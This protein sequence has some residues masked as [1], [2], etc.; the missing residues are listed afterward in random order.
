MLTWGVRMNPGN[1][2]RLTRDLAPPAIAPVTLKP[3]CCNSDVASW[4]LRS[5]LQVVVEHTYPP[6]HIPEPCRKLA[7]EGATKGAKEMLTV[8]EENQK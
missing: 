7:P 1:S 2:R 8:D 4:L 3:T 5:R 6:R